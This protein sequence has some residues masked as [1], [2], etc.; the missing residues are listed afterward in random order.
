MLRDSLEETPVLAT[1]Q[2]GEIL[3][4]VP[5][6]PHARLVLGAS[7]RLAGETQAAIRSA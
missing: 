6:H 3:K 1:E 4:A 2:A 7:H 5:S